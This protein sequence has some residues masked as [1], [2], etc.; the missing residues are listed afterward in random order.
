V[1]IQQC[2]CF[3]TTLNSPRVIQNALIA[4]SG[5]STKCGFS[6]NRVNQT[7]TRS[8]LCSDRTLVLYH[9]VSKQFPGSWSLSIVYQIKEAIT[10]D[11]WTWF[12]PVDHES[13][14]TVI[15]NK[16]CSSS[17]NFRWWKQFG[18]MKPVRF[19]YQLV[20]Q[21]C[22]TATTDIFLHKPS[23]SENTKYRLCPIYHQQLPHITLL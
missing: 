15:I 20:F 14:V 19:N 7:K 4:N 21:G 18:V 1:H 12:Q 23:N 6:R 11:N 5:S 8:H 9:R 10:R 2:F 17:S 3:E 13:I 16:L 22:K